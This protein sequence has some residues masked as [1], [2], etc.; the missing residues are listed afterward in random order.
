LGRSR[1]F[2]KRFDRLDYFDCRRSSDGDLDYIKFFLL[3]FNDTDDFGKVV[4]WTIRRS[5]ATRDVTR[6][7]QATPDMR[8]ETLDNSRDFRWRLLISARF[9]MA[10]SKDSESG[11]SSFHVRLN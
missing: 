4:D 2:L 1:R 9:F 10:F 6:G 3:F 7:F 5:R 11:W 8:L